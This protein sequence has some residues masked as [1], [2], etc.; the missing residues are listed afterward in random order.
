MLAMTEVKGTPEKCR[1]SKTVLEHGGMSWN[2]LR[3][4]FEER[5]VML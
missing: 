2:E 3:Q 5:V 1:I 4:L